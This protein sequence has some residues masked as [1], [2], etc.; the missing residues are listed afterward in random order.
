MFGEI[1]I[2]LARGTF[3]G[4]AHVTHFHCAFSE[5]PVTGGTLA[6]GAADILFGGVGCTSIS[7]GIRV[8]VPHALRTEE[9]AMALWACVMSLLS[10][11]L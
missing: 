7:G 9:F 5:Q 4:P 2:L 11:T 6:Y 1:E 10:V 3:A 8:M